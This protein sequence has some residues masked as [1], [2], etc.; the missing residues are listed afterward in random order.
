[1]NGTTSDAI[2]QFASPYPVCSQVFK[3][4]AATLGIVLDQTPAANSATAVRVWRNGTA[5]TFT[6]DF[7][8]TVATKTVTLVAPGTAGD[9]FEIVYQHTATC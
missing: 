7:T 3:S 1:V 9:R 4:N 5:L 8:V 6:T 2:L